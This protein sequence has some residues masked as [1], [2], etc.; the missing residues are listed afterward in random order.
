MS[1]LDLSDLHPDPIHQF[2]AWFTDATDHVEIA[3]A[4]TACLSTLGPNQ[5]P[6]GRMVLLKGFDPGGFVFYTNLE[7]N[8]ARALQEHPRAGMTFHWIP[9]GRQVRLRGPVVRV[10]D[11]E[12]DAYFA[13]RPRGSQL[14]AWASDQ[15]RPLA[16]RQQLEGRVAEVEARYGGG[17]IPRPPSWSGYRIQPEAMEFWQEGDYR[18]HDRFVYTRDGEG[19]SPPQRLFP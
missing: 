11:E 9:V 7:S 1:G 13:T 17:E 18:L 10:S 19:W 3:L 16:S 15:S 5:T 6:E 8:K 12:A 4:E 2:G 14:G